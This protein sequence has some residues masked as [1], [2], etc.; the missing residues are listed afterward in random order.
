MPNKFLDSP[1]Y[2]ED[3][4]KINKWLD[5]CLLKHTFGGQADSVLRSMR[6]VIQDNNKDFPFKDIIKKLKGSNKSLIFDPDEID[7]LFCHRYG[8]SYA[9]PTLALI[10]PTL[11]FKNKFHLDHIFPKSLFT[12]SKLIKRGIYN[13]EFYLE[14][15]NLISNLQLLEG[16]INEEKSNTEF[17]TWIENTYPEESQRKVFMERNFIPDID[18]SF[19]NFEEF[20]LK[21]KELM[22]N[23]Y[24]SILRF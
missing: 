10:Y 11:D 16:P 1:K 9:F 8:G 6:E 21:R 23:K 13:D 3:R 17:D 15:F 20:I 24:E 22:K 2:M 5:I 7:N 18:L 19:D 4:K 14:H 12:R